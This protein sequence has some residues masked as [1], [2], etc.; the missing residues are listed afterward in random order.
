[1]AASSKTI[2][3]RIPAQY[4]VAEPVAFDDTTYQKHYINIKPDCGNTPAN[5]NDGN[6]IIL[7]FENESKFYK[8]GDYETGFCITVGFRTQD[9]TDAANPADDRD[10]NI[11][12]HT[13]LSILGS[14]V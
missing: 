9:I 5:L 2:M 1:M 3:P 13:I 14:Y 8:L 12:Y 7:K 11:T 4:K 6:T 10:V